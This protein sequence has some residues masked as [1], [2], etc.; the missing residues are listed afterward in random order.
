MLGE[1]I[2]GLRLTRNISQV[3]IS[4]KVLALQNRPSVIGKITISCLPSRL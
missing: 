1:Q 2:K 4:K 3:P